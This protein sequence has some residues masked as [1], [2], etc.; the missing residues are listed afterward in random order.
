MFVELFSLPCKLPAAFFLGG[1]GRRK[2]GQTKIWLN[3]KLV[4]YEINVMGV[5]T[6]F[7]IS[8]IQGGDPYPLWIPGDAST[9]FAG[10][11]F[12]S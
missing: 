5:E 6:G 9:F 4:K 12:Q 7:A 11:R 2:V 3:I 1:G 8:G 10:I